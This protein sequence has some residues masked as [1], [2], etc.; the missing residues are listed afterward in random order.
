[1]YLLLVRVFGFGYELVVVVR[2]V[3]R[4][5]VK[6]VVLAVVVRLVVVVGWVVDGCAF[7]VVGGDGGESGA[8]DDGEENSGS[9]MVMI[10]L[11]YVVMGLTGVVLFV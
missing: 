5:M 3:A 9:L 11:S 2:L 4:L 8:M 1:M 10:L 7:V 6:I